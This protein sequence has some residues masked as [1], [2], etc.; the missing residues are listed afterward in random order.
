MI[1]C[2]VFLDHNMGTQHFHYLYYLQVAIGSCSDYF[3]GIMGLND[4]VELSHY[5][6]M[7]VVRF[8]SEMDHIANYFSS[9]QYFKLLDCRQVQQEQIS[10]S[11]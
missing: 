6:L 1:E 9:E 8:V 5:F 3:K 11:L 2:S 10:T 4:I 7:E